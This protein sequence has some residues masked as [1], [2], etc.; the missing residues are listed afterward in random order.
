MEVIPVIDLMNGLVVH[1]RKGERAHYQPL[2]S[3]LCKSS[4]VSEILEALLR[5]YPFPV[6]YIADLDAIQK[7]GHHLGLINQLLQQHPGLEIWIDAGINSIADIQYWAHDRLRPV[8]G[9]ES[10]PDI[11][12]WHQLSQVCAG[13]HIL[14]LDFTL[15]GYQGPPELLQSAQFW[16]SDIIVMSLPHVGSYSGPDIASLSQFRT[17]HPSHYIYA[18]GGIRHLADLQLLDARGIKG[19]LI[20]SALH[21]GNLDQAALQTILAHKTKTP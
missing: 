3:S 15:A 4:A 10:I 19:A 13:K 9:T 16:P 2:T 18:A 5:L 1:A 8:L 6:V 11:A 17:Q 14:S 7:R 12:T 21:N 20:A